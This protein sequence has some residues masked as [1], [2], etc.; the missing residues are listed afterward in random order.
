MLAYCKFVVAWLTSEKDWNDVIGVQEPALAGALGQ[1]A[2]RMQLG[3][4]AI[5]LCIL[6]VALLCQVE[7]AKPRAIHRKWIIVTT[8]NYP[9]ESIRILATMTDW[10]VSHAF[11]TL[12]PASSPVWY[13]GPYKLTLSMLLSH[14]SLHCLRQT[15]RRLK[16][17]EHAPHS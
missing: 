16:A 2:P 9:T 17:R 14:V 8:I 10:T 13:Q 3:T 11:I 7:G 15:L 12:I 5:C 6:V 4:G 1:L